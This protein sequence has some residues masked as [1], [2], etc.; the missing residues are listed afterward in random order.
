MPPPRRL[1][2]YSEQDPK[3]SAGW[4]LKTLDLNFSDQPKHQYKVFGKQY[5]KNTILKTKP[6]RWVRGD[7]KAW[8]ARHS[9]F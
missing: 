3:I 9:N 7:I 5:Q 2:Q 1:L 6:R 4:V 8:S